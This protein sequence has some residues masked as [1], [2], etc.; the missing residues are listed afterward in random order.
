MQVN[1]AAR[2]GQL[3]ATTQAKITEKAEKLR[4]YFDRVSAINVTVDL[5]CRDNHH[6]ALK[7]ELQVSAEHTEDFVA[8]EVADELF[9]ALD[10]AIHKVEQQ[11]R[12]HKEKTID[13]HR[14]PGR[15][16]YEAP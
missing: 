7:V 2:H 16:T 13:G 6:D 3:S 5:E 9:A 8:T 14:Q 4:R 12:K 10:S 1:I 11:I 15:K